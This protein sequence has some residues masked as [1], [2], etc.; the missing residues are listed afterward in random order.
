MMTL[1]MKRI[2]QLEDEI[3]DLKAI[4]DLANQN[5]TTAGNV[6]LIS[7]REPSNPIKLFMGKDQ[8]TGFYFFFQ[9]RFPG[10]GSDTWGGFET[11]SRV[12]PEEPAWGY[13]ALP[14]R[15]WGLNFLL[16]ANGDQVGRNL[17]VEKIYLQK[18][19][20]RSL[21]TGEFEKPHHYD[22]F[23]I[24]WDTQGNRMGGIYPDGSDLGVY[25]TRIDDRVV[26]VKGDK[27]VDLA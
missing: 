18:P 24:P 17:V 4:I 20:H 3:A 6:N 14:M 2:Q 25:I 12:N 19:A 5:V 8:D 26:L 23:G 27:V 11:F 1:I 10:Q 21:V 9:E 15:A 16:E 7:R 22:L 13:G